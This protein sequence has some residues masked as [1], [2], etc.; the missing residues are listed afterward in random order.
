MIKIKRV[1]EP[2]SPDDGYR[3]LIDRLWPRG[4]AREAAR[5]D[6]WARE[7]AVSDELRRWFSHDPARWEEFRTRYRAA[8]LAPENRPLLDAL[9]QRARSG[10][11]T[12]LYGAREERY[13]NAQVLREVLEELLGSASGQAGTQE[14]HSG[15]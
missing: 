12:I 3:V 11:V 5:L 6:A 14:P 4:L 9:A 8:L 13:N 2:P 1:Y 15:S 10:T 7:L